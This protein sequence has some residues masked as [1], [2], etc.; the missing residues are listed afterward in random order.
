MRSPCDASNSLVKSYGNI[1]DIQELKRE[2][3]TPQD[4]LRKVTPN[5]QLIVIREYK[6]LGEISLNTRIPTLGVIGYVYGISTAAEWVNIQ[7]LDYL[8]G[9]E[10]SI[11]VEGEDILKFSYSLVML[12]PY[13]N[14]NEFSYFLARCR[15]ADF[16]HMYGVTG[17]NQLGGMFQKFIEERNASIRAC[18]N[19]RERLRRE[20]APKPVNGL[21][22]YLEEVKKKADAGDED[23]IRILK[24]HS[25]SLSK[26][27][28]YFKKRLTPLYINLIFN[29][30]N[31]NIKDVTLQV[32]AEGFNA[33]MNGANAK[34]FMDIMSNLTASY[35]L[36]DDNHK[37][38]LG[39]GPTAFFS[40]FDLANRWNVSLEEVLSI[41]LDLQLHGLVE[42]T[43]SENEYA[44]Q[45]SISSFTTIEGVA[46]KGKACD[47]PLEE[48]GIDK[49][50]KKQAAEILA[51]YNG[52]VTLTI[53]MVTLK[54]YA[55]G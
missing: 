14:L 29:H 51:Y 1:L 15:V 5:N 33:L 20:N 38:C 49:M 26:K 7:I 34:F 54:K 52:R 21:K 39:Y 31:S 53:P 55:L 25:T 41:M 11:G 24:M 18:E 4:F 23:A 9:C 27:K 50:D 12:Y 43:L 16:G 40:L 6:R 48:L 2:A 46:F 37:P 47:A 32:S 30:M 36:D 8:K 28:S 19:E 45:P 22:A 10:Q 3:P 42:Y 17:T 35:T 13:I 44:I